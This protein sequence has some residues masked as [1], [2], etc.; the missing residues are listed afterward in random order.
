MQLSNKSGQIIALTGAI[1]SGKSYVL[2]VFET[3]G[4]Q[5]ISAD[6]L[7]KELYQKPEIVNEIAKL[8]PE[9]IKNQIVDLEVVRTKLSKNP[10]MITNLQTIV[11]PYLKEKRKELFAKYKEKT[12][13]YE[14]PLL[15]E[16]NQHNEFD[17]I[18]SLICPEAIRR[19]RAIDRGVATQIF[20][21]LNAEQTTDEVR[22]AG[23]DIIIDTN[24]TKAEI[25]QYIKS[26]I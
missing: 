12:I 16:T 13:I 2:S 18:I 6:S 11:L 24:K 15:F 4:F 20:D 19:K 5:T 23:A 21:F 7:V 3:F 8:M 10:A 17:L 26:L 25:E 22:K 9:A 1:A 14:I